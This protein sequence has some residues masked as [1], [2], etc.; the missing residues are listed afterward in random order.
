MKR[1]SIAALERRIQD[2]ITGVYGVPFNYDSDFFIFHMGDAKQA[3]HLAMSIGG[4]FEGYVNT[5]GQERIVICQVHCLDA[6]DSPLT[7]AKAIRENWKEQ[8]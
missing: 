8:V 7:L 6:W 5:Y 1:P 2:I 4:A 3:R